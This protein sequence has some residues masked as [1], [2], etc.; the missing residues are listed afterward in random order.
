[1]TMKR[2]EDLDPNVREQ[3]QR[4][5]ALLVMTKREADEANIGLPEQ[6]F[7]AADFA[8]FMLSRCWPAKEARAAVRAM[9]TMV[10]DECDRELP[11]EV[12]YAQRELW[13]QSFG[14]DAA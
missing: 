11:A 1:M 5:K 14:E 8:I 13:R 4:M 12:A 9:V 3:V 7:A 10:D 6:A 2:L